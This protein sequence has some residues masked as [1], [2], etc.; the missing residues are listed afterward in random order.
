[1][2][3]IFLSYTTY[4]ED[5]AKR[6]S[7]LFREKGWTVWLGS[8]IIIDPDLN[9][10]ELDKKVLKR[11]KAIVALWSLEASALPTVREDLRQLST[12][13]PVIV[14]LDKAA[15][16]S[17][18]S[19]IS[20]FDLSDWDGMASHAELQSLLR[21]LRRLI[22]TS[23]RPAAPPAAF[24]ELSLSEIQERASRSLKEGTVRWMTPDA[25]LKG[26]FISYRR[27][28]AAAYARGLYD[29]LAARFGRERVF[30]D[31]VNVSAGADFVEAI[32]DAAESCAVMIVLISRQWAGSFDDAHREDGDYVRLEVT[33]ALAHK[34]PLVPITIQGASMPRAKDLP[35]D[36]KPIARRNACE[37]RDVRWERDVE[38]LILDLEKILKG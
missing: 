11:A 34:I 23:S 12:A 25:R 17:D 35:D 20:A 30:L 26:V 16:L 18:F 36:L 9:L 2:S 22:V 7:A 10:A 21:H 28:E 33:T 15:P 38:D 24:E 5:K 27:D 1:M 6:L 13:L 14:L 19:P 29:R 4:D 32:T 31:M 37:L 8:P 3:D